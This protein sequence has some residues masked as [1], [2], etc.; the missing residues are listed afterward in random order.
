MIIRRLSEGIRR[1]DWFTVMVEVVIVVAGVYIG[2]FLGDAAKEREV[3]KETTQILGVLHEQLKSDLEN[4]DRIYDYRLKLRETNVEI[5][6]LLST[7]IANNQ[8]FTRIASRHESI[9]TFFPNSSAYQTLRDQGYLAKV[10]ND[11]LQFN[12]SYLYESI[13]VRHMTN[14]TESDGAGF[15]YLLEVINVYWDSENHD[16]IGDPKIAQARIQNSLK[17]MMIVTGGYIEFLKFTIR[18]ELVKNIEALD[19]YLKDQ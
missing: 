1:Q 11:D 4:V 13:Y 14:A 15:F 17:G 3:Q 16:F 18:P 2:I 12:L 5:V 19:E 8:D 10:S 9:L 6:K 7:P